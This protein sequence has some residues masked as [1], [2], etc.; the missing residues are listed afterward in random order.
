MAAWI[1]AMSFSLRLYA[2]IGNPNFPKKNNFGGTAVA[3]LSA[4]IPSIGD[5]TLEVAGTSGVA[6]KIDGIG[7]SHTPSSNGPVRFVGQSGFVYVY[8]RKSFL[9]KY[10]VNLKGIAIG[11]GNNLLQN[12]SF[13]EG[14][15]LEAGKWQAVNWSALTD[16]S[17]SAWAAGLSTSVR[18]DANFRSEGSKSLIMHSNVRNLSQQLGTDILASGSLYQISY[19]YWTA[20]G[21]GN[22]GAEYRIKLGTSLAEDNILTL[23]GHTTETTVTGQ[24]NYSAIF[25]TPSLS[26]VPI[27]FTLNR[28]VSKVDWLDNLKL[29]KVSGL[30]SGIIGVSN[31]IFLNGSTFAPEDPTLDELGGTPVDLANFVPPSANYTL[32]APG[33]ANT[34]IKIPA[35]GIAYTPNSNSTVRF[36]NQENIIYVFENGIFVTTYPSVPQYTVEETNLLQN[37][38]FEQVG[39]PLGSGNWP[40]SNWNAL[41]EDKVT[42]AWGAGSATSVREN[43]A[44]RSDGLMS[45]I[46]HTNARYL[47]QQLSPEVITPN[48]WYQISYNHWTSSGTGNGGANYQIQL[49]TGSAENDLLLIPGHS[50]A[51]GS[52]SARSFSKLFKTSAITDPAW[53]TLYRNT[54]KVDWLD[55]LKLSKV[56]GLVPGI[57]GIPSATII[58][59]SV[60]THTDEKFT[61]YKKLQKSIN[62][63]NK[64][65]G[66][67]DSDPVKQGILLPALNSAKTALNDNTLTTMQITQATTDLNAVTQS[68]DKK[69][70]IPTWMLGDVNNPDNNWAYSR[71]IQSQDWILFWE[72]GFNTEDPDSLIFSG[73]RCDVNWIFDLAER[74]FHLYADSLKFINKGS[75]KTDTYKMIIRLRYSADWEATGSGVDDTIGLLTLTP[76]AYTSRGGQTVAHEV[77]HC[78]QYQV[79][80]DNNNQ[81]G[82]MYGYGIDGSGL[83]G[84]WEQCAQW[85]AYK[86]F[87]TQQFTNEWVA[88]HLKN[89]HRHPIH[90]APRYENYFIQDYW[91]D[92][93]G[94]DF[95][96]RL[97][98]ESTRPEDPI[99]AYKRITNTTQNQFSDEMYFNA[100][101]FATWD[102][103]AVRGYGA[104][105]I[106]SRPQP[107][108]NDAGS[109]Y[110]R[111]DPTVCPENYGYNIIQL[112]A[113]N[114]QKLVSVSFQ[115]LAGTDGYRKNYVSEA[116]WRYGFVALLKN[117]TRV[118]GDINSATMDINESKEPITFLCPAECEKLW[119]VVSGAPKSYWRHSWDNNDA[120]DEQWPYQVRFGNTNLLGEENIDST[121]PVTLVSFYVRK[122]EKSAKLDW[123]TTTE[124]NNKGFYIERS[125][126]GKRFGNIGMVAG[127]GNSSQ[128]NHY[129]FTDNKPLS[130]NSYYRLRQEDLDGK[131][132]YSQIRSFTL[133]TPGTTVTVY[134]NPVKSVLEVNTGG[135]KGV[136]ILS[137]LT[138]NILKK[139]SHNDDKILQVDIHLL[140]EGLYLWQLNSHTG[141]IIKE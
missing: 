71:S 75:S 137:D 136:F 72:K 135:E 61:A 132:S 30:V 2:Q 103:D 9:K 86:V 91:M 87:P 115:G 107:K 51:L 97:W 64:V 27:W 93:H 31:A 39:T 113:P 77:A 138:G 96:G 70:Y 49:G 76:W 98:N 5:F 110:W 55:K 37:P 12:P 105:I 82:W 33:S 4:F 126:D 36:V 47:T 65:L 127:I 139:I 130:G 122:V 83:N 80:C 123:V 129:G 41:Q 140:P 54:S 43:G 66:W 42:T 79:H 99:E 131:Y 15:L 106:S 118:Y 121:L 63:A 74:S 88:G 18:E 125:V 102:I 62:Y 94:N 134:P 40:A 95:I 29:I 124:V 22:G 112:N 78:F 7:I 120:N 111:I 81:N 38:S 20:S 28:N 116:G 25:E 85:Q 46:M 53:F 69:T 109:N 10:P 60:I 16:A 14:I 73:T 68:V 1:I 117:G 13:E 141:K 48:S 52:V 108:M 11:D 21:T 26:A 44:Y 23:S 128:I 56:T 67:Y 59:N 104:S 90:E 50:T 35:I 8:E 58:E 101:R 84:W 89:T 17:S 19:D 24:K 133:D 32:E 57:I 45:V 3:D 6:I 92:L 100:A 119:L 114:T 34:E